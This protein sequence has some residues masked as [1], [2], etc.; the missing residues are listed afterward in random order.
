[1]HQPT[2]SLRSV[3]GRILFAMLACFGA[4]AASAASSGPRLFEIAVQRYVPT[5]GGT[6]LQRNYLLNAKGTLRH[7]SD[8]EVPAGIS[9]PEE[10]F[11]KVLIASSAWLAYQYL[12]EDALAN[13]DFDFVSLI[14]AQ[15][16][17]FRAWARDDAK[18]D[19]GDVVNLSTRGHVT[20]ERSL[21]AGFVVRSEARTVL[22]RA[23]GPTLAT[24]GV[25]APLGNPLLTIYKGNTPHYQN[26]DWGTR[27]EREAIIAT[28]ARVGAFALPGG[29]RDAA[30]LMELPP[31][32]YTAQVTSADGTAG[33]ALV[34]I[35]LVP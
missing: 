11:D 15:R 35:Y 7:I 22:I 3:L 13:F 24:L 4:G 31:G 16:A 28:S 33:D 21:T 23:V 25:P 2:C 6:I 14:V 27:P 20:A 12:G 32:V 17:Y 1:M 19:V 34:E 29:S 30:V 18:L 26:D 9:I 10:A 5:T 8:F